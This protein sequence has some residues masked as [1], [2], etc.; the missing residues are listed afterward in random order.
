MAVTFFG[1]KISLFSIGMGSLIALIP[2]ALISIAV[3]LSF[4]EFCVLYCLISAIS[5]LVGAAW[6][7]IENVLLPH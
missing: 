7:I 5:C 2:T 4:K 3:A 1:N 6:A